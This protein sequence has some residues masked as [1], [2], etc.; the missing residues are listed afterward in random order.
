MTMRLTLTN[1]IFVLEATY[2]EFQN[3]KANGLNYTGFKWNRDEHQWQSA[4][5]VA[6]A[7]VVKS[8]RELHNAELPMSAEAATFYASEVARVKALPKCGRCAGTGQFITMVVNG[9]PTGPGGICY[10]CNGKGVQNAR[11]EERNDNYDAISALR[12]MMA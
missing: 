1:N 4:H 2:Q 8:Y 11:D 3:A 10:R 6:A 7:R 12:Y 5:V 9:R